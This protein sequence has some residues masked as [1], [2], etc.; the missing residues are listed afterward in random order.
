MTLDSMRQSLSGA[1]SSGGDSGRKECS[2]SLGEAVWRRQNLTGFLK[3][4][5]DVTGDKVQGRWVGMGAGREDPARDEPRGRAEA[6]QTTLGKLGPGRRVSGQ[7]LLGVGINPH[8][9]EK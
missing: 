9:T 8:F 6:Q 2:G 3:C 4:K 7:T 5:Q 1:L